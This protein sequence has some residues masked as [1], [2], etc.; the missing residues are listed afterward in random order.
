[1]KGESGK[2]CVRVGRRGF[3]WE[4]FTRPV[5][6]RT[7]DAMVRRIASAIGRLA[8][9]IRSDESAPPMKAEMPARIRPFQ[10]RVDRALPSPAP[11]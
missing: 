8:E 5:F 1:M 11:L 9:L 4:R 2:A 6:T 10:P 3:V 7:N